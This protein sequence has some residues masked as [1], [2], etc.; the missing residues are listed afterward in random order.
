VPASAP[1]SFT[2]HVSSTPAAVVP[3]GANCGSGVKVEV[4]TLNTPPPDNADLGQAGPTLNSCLCWTTDTS[5]ATCVA[6]NTGCNYDQGGATGNGNG[7]PPGTTV[8]CANGTAGAQTLSLTT[9]ATINWG[10]CA[11][12]LEQ[13][14]GTQPFQTGAYTHTIQVNG[15]TS[16]WNKAAEAA[17]IAYMNEW[18]DSNAGRNNGGSCISGA[19]YG[20]FTYD[21]TSLYVGGTIGNAFTNNCCNY[22]GGCQGGAC[23]GAANTWVV[24][25]IGDFNGTTGATSELPQ[26]EPDT[27]EGARSIS[28]AAGIK[29]AFAWNTSGTTVNTYQWTGTSWAAATFTVLPA[30]DPTT[31]EF[32]LG[33]PFA[34]VGITAGVSNVSFFGVAIADQGVAQQVGDGTNELF[35]FP[36]AFDGNFPQYDLFY[37]DS[38]SSCIV[39]NQ[40]VQGG[41]SGGNNCD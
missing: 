33:I 12:G 4:A 26:F 35:R 16:E 36:Y 9:N 40:G 27:Y 19:G 41:N 5:A 24:G 34:G 7:G 25:Y 39:P 2:F 11:F 13:R 38:L 29:Y 14:S 21:G 1:E 22:N 37:Q 23:L 31:N 20:L 32:E 18:P 30:F 10:T 17:N 15:N 3:A 6:N 8:H 28:L